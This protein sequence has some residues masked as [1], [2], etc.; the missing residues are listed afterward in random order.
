MRRSPVTRRRWHRRRGSVTAHPRHRSFGAD[1]L[2]GHISQRAGVRDIKQRGAAQ[3]EGLD[4]LHDS[5]WLARDLETVDV[6]GHCE[7]RR[8]LSVEEISVPKIA[9]VVRTTKHDF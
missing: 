7:Q 5:N 2:A 8:S 4:A 3:L 1:Q 6:E 9:G